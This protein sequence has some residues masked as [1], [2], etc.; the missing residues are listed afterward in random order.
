MLD[1][2]GSRIG[3]ESS[4]IVGVFRLV[5]LLEPLIALLLE[6]VRH[7]LNGLLD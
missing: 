4:R 5:K 7:V 3:H 2:G 1:L 6:H